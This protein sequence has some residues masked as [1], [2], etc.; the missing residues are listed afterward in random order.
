[1]APRP[2]TNPP[3]QRGLFDPCPATL[4]LVADYVRAG[5]DGCPRCGRPADEHE[6]EE[7]IAGTVPDDADFAEWIVNLPRSP[8]P[9]K[10]P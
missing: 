8:Q 2:S 10:G 4:E 7:A 1:V 6:L 5:G 9:T 3:A